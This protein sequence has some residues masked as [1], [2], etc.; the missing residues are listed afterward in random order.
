MSVE[1]KYY[2]I[3]G[4]DLTGYETD[5]FKDWKWTDEGENIHV[6]KLRIGFKFL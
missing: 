4:Y 6:I 3:V 1:S 5:K 2:A